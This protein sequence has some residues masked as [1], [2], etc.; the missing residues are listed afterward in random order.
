MRAGGILAVDVVAGL[1]LAEDLFA[2]SGIRSG[3]HFGKGRAFLGNG[4]GLT[5][6]FGGDAVGLLALRQFMAGTEQR[7]GTPSDQHEHQQR[8]AKR[9]NRLGHFHRVEHVAPSLRL[10]GPKPDLRLSIRF[11]PFHHR[12]P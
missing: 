11:P 7:L 9:A 2:G 5:A 8:P 4:L 10:V 6:L 1:A 3:E 12:I